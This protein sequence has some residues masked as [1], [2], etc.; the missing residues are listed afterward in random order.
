MSSCRYTI[1]LTPEPDGSAFTVTVPMLP[2]CV[3]FGATRDE[4]IANAREAILCHVRGL[5]MDGEP[6]PT[7]SLPPELLTLHLEPAQ[8]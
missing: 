3:T 2:G 6:I 5:A 7:E 8:A 1:L 4:A